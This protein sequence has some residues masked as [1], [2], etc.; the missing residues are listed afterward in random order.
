MREGSVIEDVDS[1]PTIGGGVRDVYGEDAATEEQFVTPWSLSVARW[2]TNDLLFYSNIYA[3]Q[4][5][6]SFIFINNVY[7][8]MISM[9]L[10]P[11]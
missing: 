1:K 9:S 6:L 11:L 7:V 5:S 3:L 8:P 4:I 2:E 10:F